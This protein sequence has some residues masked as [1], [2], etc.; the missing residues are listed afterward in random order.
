MCL[1]CGCLIHEHS[2]PHISIIRRQPCFIRRNK[3]SLRYCNENFLPSTKSDLHTKGLSVT[4]PPQAPK[5]F[6]W[7]SSAGTP[8]PAL[9][10][11]SSVSALCFLSSFIG[12]GEL[13][14]WLQNIVGVSN[15]VCPYYFAAVQSLS[16]HYRSHGSP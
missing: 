3:S 11:T 7:T 9:L 1:S 8:I 4:D 16:D 6:C 2:N 13:W 14:G 5:I 15:Q 10:M 12:S